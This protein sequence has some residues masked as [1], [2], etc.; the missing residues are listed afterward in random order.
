MTTR[1][2]IDGYVDKTGHV[3]IFSRGEPAL[4]ES[5]VCFDVRKMYGLGLTRE[6][7]H[8]DLRMLFSHDGELSSLARAK[9]C[10]SAEKL[11]AAEKRFS[12]H[13]KAI[14]EAKMD[15]EKIPLGDLIPEDVVDEFMQ[16]RLFVIEE[17]WDK[18]TSSD[19]HS[20]EQLV[21]P[22]FQDILK[23]EASR[24]RID[25]PFIE[26]Q[27]KDMN[28]A[29][30][31]RKFLQH[32]LGVTKDGFARTRISPVGSKTWRLRVESGFNCM[33]V[34]HGVCR[35]AITSRFDGGSIVSLDFNAI[36]YRSLVDAVNDP[37]LNAIYGGKEDFHHETALLFGNVDKELRNLVKKITYSHI[38]GSSFE[39]L[40]KTTGLPRDRLTSMLL[41]LDKRFAP[42][43]EF[44]KKLSEE[45]RKSGYLITP[46]HHRV[47]IDPKDHD[48]KII[49]LYAQT[50]SAYV[51]NRS[52]HAVLAILESFPDSGPGGARSRV[53]FTV[54][55]EILFDVHPEERRVIDILARTVKAVTGFSVKVKE[56]KSYG[57]ATD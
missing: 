55:D 5:H 18:V 57:E 34:P 19:V 49:G 30:H 15:I 16:M 28:L 36:D 17:L 52:L 56:G 51:L 23:V 44:R 35:Q 50:Y 31:E 29:V 4:G 20:Y 2:I 42:I 38:Y 14:S 21:W 53:I 54:H 48:G 6:K 11:T 1:R 22:T 8:Y 12:A 3:S 25:M 43:S 46:G 40:Q 37:G 41:I 27:L 24:V 26:R 39:G 9:D 13:T 45:S 33:A 47:E 10:Q 32:M 7:V